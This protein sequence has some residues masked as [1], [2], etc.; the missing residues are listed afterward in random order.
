MKDIMISLLL[1]AY[2]QATAQST[3]T[4]LPVKP[5][6]TS[7]QFLGDFD[8]DNCDFDTNNNFC[9]TVVSGNFTGATLIR[10]DDWQ[11]GGDIPSLIITP[12][13]HIPEK[14]FHGDTIKV[15]GADVGE[16]WEWGF[17][18]Y[19]RVGNAYGGIESDTI[20]TNDYIS[21]DILDFIYGPSDIEA[22]ET[23]VGKGGI[24]IGQLTLRCPAPAHLCDLQGRQ[25]RP[26]HTG[27]GLLFRVPRHGIYLLRTRK[28]GR[29]VAMKIAL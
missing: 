7:V 14:C 13:F 6:I 23:P 16:I 5:V 12:V 20:H 15:S 4:Q 22:V 21:Q 26:E 29:Q 28:D 17:I 27:I 11:Y 24:S 1:I 18:Y 2:L 3:S 19:I 9:I 8:Y 10:S 25:V